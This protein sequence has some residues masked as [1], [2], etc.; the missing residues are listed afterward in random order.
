MAGTNPQQS[1]TPDFIADTSGATPDFIPH[2][3]ESASGQNQLTQQRQAF[4][5]GVQESPLGQFFTNFGKD[6]KGAVTAPYEM[7]KD[8]VTRFPESVFGKDTT[9]NRFIDQPTEAPAAKASQA[10]SQ[11]RYSEAA[12][13]GGAAT[14]LGAGPWAAEKGEQIGGGDIAGGLGGLTGGL[15]GAKAGEKIGEIPKSVPDFIRRA[16]TINDITKAGAG[17]YQ[18]TVQP[19]FQTLGERIKAE[20]ARTIQQ[21]I[22]ADKTA[23]LVPGQGTISVA[24]AVTAAAEAIEKTGYAESPKMR[25]LMA[26]LQNAA[27]LNLEDAKNLRS[28]FGEAASKARAANDMKA[29]SIYTAGYDA[30]GEGMKGRVKELQGTEDPYTHYNNEFKSYYELRDGIAGQM[31]KSIADRHEAIPQL[32]KFRDA[33]L[34]ELKEQAK[35]YGMDP[36]KFDQAQKDAKAVTAAHGA[37]QGK[38]NKSLMRVV[39]DNKSSAAAVTGLAVY[40]AAHGAGLY[41]IA[42]ILAGMF[43]ANTM[44]SLPDKIEAGRVLQKLKVNPESFQVRNP[45]EGPKAFNYPNQDDVYNPPPRP[46]KTP[47]PEEPPITPESQAADLQRLMEMRRSALPQRQASPE[48]SPPEEAL[49]QQSVFGEKSPEDVGNKVRAANPEPT[50]KEVKAAAIKKAKR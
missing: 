12:G 29:N 43:A 49:W 25:G 28:E 7:G 45:V 21:A 2:P 16:K 14:L 4:V 22:E 32:E 50:R 15:T 35:K 19:L 36:A 24:P 20:G 31:M 27:L 41:G 46:S 33:D 13:Y 9:Y 23:T 5:S 30:L 10:L 17:T 48:M 40:A 11:G 42:P 37:M 3:L 39:M 1:S 8:V 6:F 38:Y 44:R 26:R 34:S 47:P 18:A